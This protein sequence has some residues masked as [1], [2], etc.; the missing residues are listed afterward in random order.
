MD[1]DEQPRKCTFLVT[2][3]EKQK[4][5]SSLC[6]NLLRH[7]GLD[8]GRSLDQ[9]RNNLV[10]LLL[11]SSL[12]LLQLLLSLHVRIVLG[13]LESARVLRQCQSSIQRGP[14][15][16][17]HSTEIILGLLERYLTSASNFL[18]SSSFWLRYSSI[19]F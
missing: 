10:T 4:P 9:V 13:L 3:E 14:Q 8:I 18:Y 1:I 12:N 19:S 5:N 11:A 2:T 6:S 16:G 7:L 15:E 17:Q